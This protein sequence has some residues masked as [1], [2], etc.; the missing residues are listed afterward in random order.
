MNKYE[1]DISTLGNPNRVKRVE[2]TK[3]W[4]DE[5]HLRMDD[6]SGTV[7]VFGPGQ[8]RSVQRKDDDS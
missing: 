5:G 2:A 4:V 6:S 7:A 3:V 1:V 8:W